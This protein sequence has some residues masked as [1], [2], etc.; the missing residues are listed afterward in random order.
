V[1]T[2]AA[3]A[4]A[5]AI[6]RV[7]IVDDE[8][9]IRLIAELSLRRVGGWEV[10]SAGSGGEALALAASF[11]PDVI[12]L[13]VMMPTMDGPMTL[14]RLRQQPALAA[15]PVIFITARAQRHE[16]ERY[17]EVGAAGVIVKPF[18]PMSLPGEIRRL[19]G[20]A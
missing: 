4:D 8:P 16:V 15:V 19:V 18:D 17:R 13:D 14:R 1:L 6:Q 3:R 7:L 9:D 20:G 10:A 12:L 2:V 5:S 11:R